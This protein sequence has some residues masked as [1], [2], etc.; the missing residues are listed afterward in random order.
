[1]KIKI[2]NFK[3]MRKNRWVLGLVIILII[4][5]GLY[6]VDSKDKKNIVPITI[7]YQRI[8]NVS[9][10]VDKSFIE[11][12]YI[13]DTP[14]STDVFS[15]IS[16]SKF[17]KLFKGLNESKEILIKSFYVD[18]VPLY[19][20]AN[21]NG[22]HGGITYNY[23]IVVDIFHD[24]KVLYETNEAFGISGFNSKIWASPEG[25][26]Q[27]MMIYKQMYLNGGGRS[28]GFELR[29]FLIY[30]KSQNKFITENTKHIDE[31]SKILETIK[32]TGKDQTISDK[33]YSAI[34]S[35]Y[36]NILNGKEESLLN[37]NLGN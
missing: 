20:L 32:K 3:N 13:H 8:D 1:M 36:E 29:D 23:G 25:D 14:E 10:L 37:L 16:D 33:E 28:D 27:V 26:L 11:F 21:V 34:T 17:P 19:I 35:T 6:Y 24:N 22:D 2:P 30:D 18:N 9:Y 15:T 5:G 7:N 12:R 31:I 4:A